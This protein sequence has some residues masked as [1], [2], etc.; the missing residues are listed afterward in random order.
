M[1]QLHL[2][3]VPG[4]NPK[5]LDEETQRMARDLLAQLLLAVA[6]EKTQQSTTHTGGHHGRDHK[7][8]S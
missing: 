7:T 4:A 3:P 1:E 6:T 2:F 8:P 5:P